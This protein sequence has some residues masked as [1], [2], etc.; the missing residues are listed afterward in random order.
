MQ[1]IH[2]NTTRR[3][4]LGGVPIGGGSPVVVQSMCNTDTR[5]V[6][7]TLGQ[8]GRLHAAGCEIVR[9]AVPDM[10][11]AE[12]L[13][14]IAAASP[15]PL[16]ADIHFD[17]RLAL[18][19]LD[20]GLRGLRINPGNIGGSGPV[21]SVAAAAKANG[22]VIRVG[23]NS[24]SVEKE[25]LEKFG[26]PTPEALVE[27]A[28]RHVAMLEKRGFYDTKIS[29]K[30]SSVRPTIEPYRP[31]ASRVQLLP[32][33]QTTLAFLAWSMTIFM[34]FWCSSGVRVAGSPVE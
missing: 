18:A 10:K 6:E 29:L 33:P 22:A 31:T 4:N 3:L 34:T 23:V 21:D 14:R 13:K 32:A 17:Y 9:L 1:S 7:S 5:D 8:I 25:L 11:A 12:A 27:S 16:I 20:A 30:S 15:V 19:A 2:R 26:G 28:L 24:G